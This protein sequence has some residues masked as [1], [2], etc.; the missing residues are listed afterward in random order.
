[1]CL[2][3]L[4]RVSPGLIKWTRPKGVDST[5]LFPVEA[6][7]AVRKVTQR[8]AGVSNWIIIRVK[9]A[10]H[11]LSQL[12]NLSS[13]LSQKSLLS[14]ERSDRVRSNSSKTSSVRFWNLK[15][16]CCAHSWFFLSSAPEL[17]KEGLTLQT[18]SRMSCEGELWHIGSSPG[19]S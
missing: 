9:L 8:V 13:E 12:A 18:S 5:M 6:L 19:G 3:S 15:N 7:T 1:M 14:V 17:L 10:G 4:G 11:I 16:T 2:P